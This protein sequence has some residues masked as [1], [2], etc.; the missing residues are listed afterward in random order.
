MNEK[1]GSID[2]H[3]SSFFIHS[4]IV[5]D[6]LMRNNSIMLMLAHGRVWLRKN[7]SRLGKSSV[8]IVYM[9]AKKFVSTMPTTS[10]AT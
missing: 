10:C 3:F 9:F 4:F 8:A 6:D 7:S 5:L 1:E 2:R